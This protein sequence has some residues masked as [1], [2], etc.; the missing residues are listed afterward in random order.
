ML[1]SSIHYLFLS[2]LI[3]GASLTTDTINICL[4]FFFEFFRTK[5]IYVC[6]HFDLVELLPKTEIKQLKINILI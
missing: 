6:F 1:V 2:L 5:L 4:T 3:A